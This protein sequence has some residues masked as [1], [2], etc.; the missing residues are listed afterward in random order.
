[1]KEA[2]QCDEQVGQS[3]NGCRCNF[4]N[5]NDEA[6]GWAIDTWPRGASVI[7]N[8]VF[9]GTALIYLG[10]EAAGC[11]TEPPEGET[12]VPPCLNRVYGIRPS[13]ILT[14]LLFAVGIC[15]SLLMPIIGTIIDHT[16]YRRA[17]GR[18]TAIAQ[19][20][21]TFFSIFVSSKIWFFV[22]IAQV[23]SAFLYI[24]HSLCT[25]AYLPELTEDKNELN[26]YT[27][28][29]TGIQYSGMLFYLVLMVALQMIL[30]IADDD[31]K[32]AQVSQ[33]VS[34]SFALVLYTYAWAKLFKPRKASQQVPENQW[35]VTAGFHKLFN[36]LREIMLRNKAM[37]WFILTIALSEAATSSFTTIAVT[38]TTDQLMFTASENGIAILILLVSSIPGKYSKAFL[39]QKFNIHGTS[40]YAV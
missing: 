11:A 22:C 37:K 5:G 9:I 23:L 12:E 40:S 21:C 7:G 25:F 35:L 28:A 30:G 27:A 17:V 16:D 6:L 2:G 38:Y 15:S 34:F 24:A 19:A 18:A 20:S 36:T 3:K 4:F 32:S 33:A 31:V 14:T 39:L 10:K 26:K 1:M 13:S 8:V 29:F